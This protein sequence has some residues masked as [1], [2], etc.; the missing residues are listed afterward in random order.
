LEY[1]NSE[2]DSQ[3]PLLE[4]LD[5]NPR[6]ILY[7]VRCVLLPFRFDRSVLLSNPDFWGPMAVVLTYSLFI[8][9]GQ[10]SVVSWILTM[11]MSGSFLIFALG[12]VLGADITFSQVL[13]VIGYSILPL[14]LAVLLCS[15]VPDIVFS[16]IVKAASTKWATFSAATLLSQFPPERL[17]E[18]RIMLSY[19]LLLLF[20]YFISL[21]SGV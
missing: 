9:W 15:V 19:P 1:D 6:E 16:T 20:V 10:I 14:T 2:E 11:W 21:S 17:S 18:K 13:G 4:E 7:K 8:I 3:L 5:I 12:R